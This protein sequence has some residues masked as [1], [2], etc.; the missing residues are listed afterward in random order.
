M[1]R[2][3]KESQETHRE[4]IAAAAERLFS[5]QGVAAATM[6]SIAR[7]AGYSKATLYVYFTNKEEIVGYLVLKSMR[8]LAFY[9]S[10]AISSS[11]TV[12]E[13]YV[14]ICNAL[15]GYQERYP[16]YFSLALGE[17]NVNLEKEDCLLAERETYA[18]GEQIN[19]AVE[20]FIRE[21]IEAGALQP[22][23]PVLQ[24]VFLFWSTL[25]GLIQT[26]ADK[27]IYI[28]KTMGLSRQAFLDFG[29]ER[30]YKMIERGK[31]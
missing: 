7:E 12:K 15:A 3:K 28:Q 22:D 19:S 27:A 10:Q 13:R 24:T 29:F 2:R 21:G 30:L 14:G 11:G 4:N 9:I 20:T 8:L 6:D 23:I 1:G 31:E 17:I 16:F 5:K 18:V 25:A 26:A